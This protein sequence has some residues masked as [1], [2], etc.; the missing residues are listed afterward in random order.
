MR[1]RYTAFA[2]GDIDY[3]VKTVHPDHRDDVDREAAEK[4]SSDADWQGLEIVKTGGGGPD[5]DTGFVEFIAR[6][7]MDGSD[8]EHH[9]HA[10]FSKKDGVWFFEDGRIVKS[11]PVVRDAPKVGR[12]EPCP[13]GSG[14][15]YKKCCGS[16]LN[17]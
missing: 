3:I 8:S 15:K 2:L 7:T 11:Q 17:R 12:N 1:S 5:D 14:K 10:Q 9:E 16:P 6:Y 4:W 13:C